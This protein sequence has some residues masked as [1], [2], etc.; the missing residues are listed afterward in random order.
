MAII[1]SPFIVAQE[2][3]KLSLDHIALSVEDLNKSISF[4]TDILNLKE[5]TDRDKK[6]GISWIALGEG[7][8]LHLHT[9]INQRIMINKANHFALTVDNIDAFAA[10][11][12][13]KKSNLLKIGKEL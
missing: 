4:Y 5:I 1:F 8:E 11:V 6:K 12:N 3:F 10:M 7:K 2:S 13:S 9:T